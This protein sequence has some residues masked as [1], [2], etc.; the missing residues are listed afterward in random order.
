MHLSH[1]LAPLLSERSERCG[2]FLQLLENIF[3]HADLLLRSILGN[4][5]RRRSGSRR[6][7]GCGAGCGGDI[8][9]G[10]RFESCQGFTGGRDFL[11]E[12]RDDAA[13][14]VVLVQRVRQLLTRRLQLLT[15]RKGM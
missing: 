4:F 7:R 12:T 1:L 5:R 10:L 15:K 3:G 6:V 2:G 9:G 14:G 13:G 8:N 11:S